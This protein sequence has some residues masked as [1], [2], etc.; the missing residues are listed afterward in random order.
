MY[1]DKDF[2]GK[3]SYIKST[4]DSTGIMTN[5]NITGKVNE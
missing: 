3:S 1:N 5:N 2:E 4:R